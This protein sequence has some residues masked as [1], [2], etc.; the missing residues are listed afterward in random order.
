M[1][2]K[3]A[4]HWGLA[5]A[6][7]LAIAVSPACAASCPHGDG[8]VA[9][10]SSSDRRAALLC[11]IGA[12]RGARGLAGV[13]E[14]GPLTLAA[15]RHA[16]DM[17][18]RGYFGHVTPGSVTLANRVG[19]TG[20]MRGWPSWQ[21]GEAIAWAQEPLDTA[22]TLVQAWMGS[23][24]HR[25]ILLDRTYRDVGI[26]VTLGLPVDLS[27]AGATA[28]LDFGARSSSTLGTW[29]SRSATACVRTARQSPPKRNRCASTSTRSKRSSQ[30]HR[31]R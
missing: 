7:L 19:I 11:V 31:R 2:G 13:R 22:T 23:S 12:E 3:G 5:A 20:Y 4:I 28:V 26:G 27:G 9:G 24:S 18:A 10:L 21:L 25:A 29:R 14:S 8:V 1:G 30:A 6:S 16:D 17:V 15:Q